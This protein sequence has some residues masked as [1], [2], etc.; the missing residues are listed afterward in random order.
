MREVAHSALRIL[1]LDYDITLIS[2]GAS[3]DYEIVMWDKPRN[4]HF[5]IRVRWEPGLSREDM[6]DRVVQQLAERSA[7]WRL[8][9]VRG[10]A[11][12]RR[13][14]SGARRWVSSGASR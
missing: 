10:F 12:R 8:A 14:R 13:R 3:N 2:G 6:T 7:A 4:S 1:N 11:E 5:S 9:D